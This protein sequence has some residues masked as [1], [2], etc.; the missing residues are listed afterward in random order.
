MSYPP[1]EHILMLSL[2]G[3]VIFF[4][5]GWLRERGERKEILET[6]EQIFDKFFGRGFT[7]RDLEN[8][9]DPEYRPY[10]D[11]ALKKL[12]DAYIIYK[13]GNQYYLREGFL[14]MSEEK[15]REAERV[16]AGDKILYGSYQHLI[17][18][19][20]WLLV[21]PLAPLIAAGIFIY[22]V[23]TNAF[24]LDALIRQRLDPTVS[25]DMFYILIVALAFVLF[26]ALLRFIRTFGEQIYT[27][28]V[29]EKGGI[30]FVEH[31]GGGFEGRIRRGQIR[32]VRVRI[33]P[34]Q[35]IYSF[36]S[37]VPIGN[38]IV[39]YVGQPEELTLKE[40]EEK[41]EK[42]EEEKEKKRKKG[43]HEVKELKTT[44][45]RPI[46]RRIVEG[47]RYHEVEFQFIPYPN[48]LAGI[49]RGVMLRNL[50]WRL[51]HAER[52]AM[53]RV[54]RFGGAAVMVGRR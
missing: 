42:E 31:V 44:V 4:I 28:V 50:S 46:K 15:Y 24:G 20:P 41:R 47:G 45:T 36:F 19:R 33:S 26:E 32:D 14:F 34:F 48:L 49:I 29:G 11:I 18:A 8:S 43:R 23:T 38:V 3:F 13:K 39:K 37:P 52:L 1:V 6:I 51:R 10:I 9:L 54:G 27:V 25:V 17:L 35:R 53:W 30:I 22:L 21:I 2:T 12:E 5:I 16:L 40:E 7:K